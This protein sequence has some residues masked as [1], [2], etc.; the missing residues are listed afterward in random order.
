VYLIFFKRHKEISE[1]KFNI[2]KIFFSIT[3]K[4]SRWDKDP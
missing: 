2:F 4:E 3:T 1:I